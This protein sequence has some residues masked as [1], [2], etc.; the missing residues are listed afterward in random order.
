MTV[1]IHHY[2]E[3]RKNIAM[4]MFDLYQ[5]LYQGNLQLI[6]WMQARNLLK[7]QMR[8]AARNCR[9]QMQLQARD[10]QDG[11]RWRC[12]F[13]R[14][15]SSKTIRDGSFFAQ[16]NLTLQQ[17]IFVIYCWCVGMS[18]STTTI[19]IGLAEKTVIDWFNFLREECSAKLVRMPWQDKLIG[20]VGEIVEVDESVMIKRKYNRGHYREQHN[21][22]VFGMYDRQRRVGWIEFVESR[23]A[24][25]LLPL[26]QRYVRPGTMIYSDGWA[27]YNNLPNIGYG[28][29]RVIHADNFVDPVTGVHTNGVEAYWSRAK[30]KLKAV[31]GSRLHMVPSYLDEYL[32]RE[33]FGLQTAAA[34][35]NMLAHIAE[36]YN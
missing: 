29:D 31:Y 15:R 17:L 34:F 22:W 33:R 35:D 8:C 14:C 3:K 27:A 1:L 6:Q 23:D 2:N 21:Q 36:H 9:R 19:V 30:Q 16:S 13:A 18:M 20:G 12:S 10:G 32:W 7:P 25:T 11:Y 26:I 4:N 24:P 5:I 28:H